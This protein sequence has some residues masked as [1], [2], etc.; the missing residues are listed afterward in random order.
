MKKVSTLF[1]L[2]CFLTGLAQKPG[3]K[4]VSAP[5]SSFNAG[6][7]GT[8]YAMI[9]GISKYQHFPSLKFADNDARAFYDYLIN[10]SGEKVDSANI[11]ILLNERA[12]AGDIWRDFGWLTRKANKKGDRVFIYFS[13]HGDAA[14]AE[15]AYLLAHDAPNEGDPNLYNAG[16]TFQIYN[17]KTKI[18]QLSEMGVQV[19]LITDA[20]RTNE[21]PGKESGSLWTFNK[22]MEKQSGEIQMASCAANEK[23]LESTNWGNGRGVFSWHLIN[24]LYGL[25]DDDPEDGNVTLY[26]LQKYVKSKVRTDTKGANGVPA[27]NPMF[28]CNE[29]ENIALS[30]P[31][32]QQK[33]ALLASINNQAITN[34]LMAMNINRSVLPDIKKIGLLYAR[35]L[36]AITNEQLTGREGNTAE[37]YYDQ[38]MVTPGL[39]PDALKEITDE[40]VAGLVNFAQQRVNNYLSGKNQKLYSF[41]YFIKA[42]DALDKAYQLIP[43][44]SEQSKIVLKTRYMLQARAASATVIFHDFHENKSQ[45]DLM[46]QAL[47]ILD[48]A[49]RITISASDALLFH[50]YSLTLQ[51]LNDIP[52]AIAYELEA[53]KMAPAWKYPYNTLGYLYS[54][55]G[56]ADSAIYYYKKCIELDPLYT[57]AYN[58]LGLLYMNQNN[59]ELAGMYFGKCIALDPTYLNAW[60]NTGLWYY[61]MKQTDSAES[62]YKRCI[63]LDSSFSN[64]HFNL[65]ALYYNKKDYER[66]TLH[67]AKC[68]QL[69]PKFAKAHF[70]L[71]CIYSAGNDMTKAAK[72]FE[73]ALKNGYNEVRF[74][75]ENSD[76]AN[77]RKTE[78]YRKLRKK[79]LP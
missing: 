24:G 27:Q 52:A 3:E 4:G 47:V 12:K 29:M 30:K 22:I 1:A 17:L 60:V 36:D 8:T 11:R 72:H 49:R 45:K 73:E 33:N 5:A 51:G 65:A 41:D 69:D 66:A 31:D 74:I 63:G 35:F 64:A 62:C 71:S 21:L 70:A 40:F 19:V 42:A 10:S 14:N 23:S 39:T 76:L 43:K 53:V 6:A 37:A 38:L 59:N 34:N 61:K 26:E 2:L 32:A 57:T 50:T 46:K 7:K 78:T 77:F 9:I 44:E 13:G 48:S 68:V 67:F 16:G 20:C 18:K 55:L 54:R 28:C 58:N 56:K 79:Y 15:E 25:A 75:E